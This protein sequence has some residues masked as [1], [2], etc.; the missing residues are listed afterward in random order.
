MSIHQSFQKEFIILIGT[1]LMQTLRPLKIMRMV[2]I[3]FI[4]QSSPDIRNSQ[5]VDGPFGM[6]P[7]QLADVALK[8]F[9]NREQQKKQED[10]R[11]KATLPG[12]SSGLPEHE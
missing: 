7:S 5:K 6:T 1:T 9:N 10:A 8:V 11:L 4:G 2:N 12:G 3:I